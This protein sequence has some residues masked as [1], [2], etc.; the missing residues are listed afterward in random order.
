MTIIFQTTFDIP[1]WDQ[2]TAS[3]P[4]DADLP[5][6]G[7][8]IESFGG[9]STSGGS[10]DL[11]NASGNMAAGGGGKG[12]RHAIGDG[13]NNGGGAILL[14]IAPLT[15]FWMRWYVRYPLGFQWS[16]PGAIGDAV[17]NKQIYTLFTGG[18]PNI[19]GGVEWGG[20]AYTIQGDPVDHGFGIAGIHIGTL[21]WRDAYCGGGTT[22]LGQW[23][24]NEIHCKINQVGAV[25]D[26]IF[27]FKFDDVLIS[28]ETGIRIVTGNA[29]SLTQVRVG[30]NHTT[31]ANGADVYQ[32]FDDIAI[33]NSGW[34]GPVS[35]NGG[36]VI[37][38]DGTAWAGGSICTY[39]GSTVRLVRT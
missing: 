35:G 11:V 2:E 16:D 23:H 20:V 5:P 39:N 38:K 17:F 32:D 9:F 29:V 3:P 4:G 27:E 25:S 30:E 1:D 31:P 26:G 19:Y 6:D 21:N 8:G 28:S 36:G 14:R 10:W 13:T 18:Q 7:D 24:F 37:A 34:I 15:E 33:S 22:S 12:Y